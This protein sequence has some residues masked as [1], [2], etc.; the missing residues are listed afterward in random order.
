MNGLSSVQVD[1]MQD[2]RGANANHNKGKTGRI[3]GKAQQALSRNTGLRLKLDDL[4]Q[5]S[6]S[7]CVKRLRLIKSVIHVDVNLT[8]LNVASAQV[9]GGP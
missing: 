1:C 2:K 5:W 3:L 9:L 4:C 7:K 8:V 6:R